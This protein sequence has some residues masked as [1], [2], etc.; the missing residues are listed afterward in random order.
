MRRLV[1]VVV[2]LHF[3][4]LVTA[5]WAQ[6][7]NRLPVVGVLTGAAASDD[8]IVK[9]LQQGLRELGYVEGNNIRIEF[10]TAQGD[11]DRL[12]RLAEELVPL[13]PDAIVTTSTLAAEAVKRATSTIP[14]VMGVAADPVGAGLV[15]NLSHPGANI[16]GLSVMSAE[17]SAKRLQLLREA[18]PRLTRVGVLRHP[19]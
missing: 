17:L 7:P 19:L 14:I 9:G 4:V 18:I 1:L 10:R 3:A 8:P 13:K 6:Q 12:P 11:S 16:T 15:T 5:A 2:A